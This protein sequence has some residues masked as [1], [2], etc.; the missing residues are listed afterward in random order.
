MMI[1]LC[2]IKGNSYIIIDVV[3][4]IL[5]FYYNDFRILVILDV[6]INNNKFFLVVIIVFEN[7]VLIDCLCF[8]IR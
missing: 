4:E 1:M 7:I 2:Y 5:Y 3:D 8:K 6:Y